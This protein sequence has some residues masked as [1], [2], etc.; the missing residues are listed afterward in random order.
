[1]IWAVCYKKQEI[2]QNRLSCATSWLEYLELWLNDDPASEICSS[3]T[4]T[5]TTV[6]LYPLVNHIQYKS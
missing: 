6:T 2:S 5:V 1:M 3:T 4:G